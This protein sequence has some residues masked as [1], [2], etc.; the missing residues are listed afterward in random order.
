MDIEKTL[1]RFIVDE[2]LLGKK[3]SIGVDESLIGSG[4]LDSL[5]LLEL[6]AFVEKR[7]NVKVADSDMVPDN[8]KTISR[9]KTFIET[10]A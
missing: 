2:L 7:F 10:R 6:I 3:A 9:I 1:E 4:I 8:F 5:T